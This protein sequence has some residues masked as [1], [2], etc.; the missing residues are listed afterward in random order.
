MAS[1]YTEAADRKRLSLGAMAKGPKR[2]LLLL[3]V[4]AT[5]PRRKMGDGRYLALS[6]HPNA[7]NRCSLS[8]AQQTLIRRAAVSANDPNRTFSDSLLGCCLPLHSE[9]DRHCHSAQKKENGDDC[10]SNRR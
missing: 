2:F 8:G 9:E 7:H 10:F 4:I 1:L 5:D 6:G 3:F